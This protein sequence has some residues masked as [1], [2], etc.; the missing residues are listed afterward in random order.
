[1]ENSVAYIRT[2]HDFYTKTLSVGA[3]RVVKEEGNFLTLHIDGKKF[4][5]YQ[6]PIAVKVNSVC[7]LFPSTSNKIKKDLEYI[8]D[9]YEDYLCGLK[10]VHRGKGFK[11]YLYNVSGKCVKVIKHSYFTINWFPLKIRKKKRTPRVKKQKKT[12]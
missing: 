3:V 5:H 11:I 1:M 8:L 10:I 12:K 2:L 4:F 6:E 7:Y 9:N